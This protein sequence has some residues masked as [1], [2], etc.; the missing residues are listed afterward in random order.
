MKTFKLKA[1]N[2]MEEQDGEIIPNRIPL[3]DGLIINREDDKN[4]WTI[5]AYIDHSYASYFQELRQLKSEI[6]VQVKI[7]KESNDIA[8]FITSMISINDIGSNLNVLFVGNIVDRRKANIESMLTTLIE[9]GYQG[10]ELL[11][12]FKEIT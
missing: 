3:L 5:E 1:L 4:Q 8:T 11:K 12:K 6:L 7:T 10:K 9:E 2:V